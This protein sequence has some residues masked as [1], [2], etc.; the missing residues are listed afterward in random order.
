MHLL[1]GHKKNIQQCI[2]FNNKLYNYIRKIKILWLVKLHNFMTVT[3]CLYLKTPILK[4]QTSILNN[5][6]LKLYLLN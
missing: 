3:W 1:A 6:I 2:T 5:I 4:V